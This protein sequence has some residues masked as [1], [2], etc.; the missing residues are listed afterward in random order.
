M[1]VGDTILYSSPHGKIRVEFP[2]GSL[3][4]LSSGPATITD[5]SGIL[6]LVKAGRFDSRC[7]VTPPNSPEIGWTK[8]YPASGGVHDVGN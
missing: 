7:Y 8:D 4:D 6:T 5:E 2:D 3:F 1:N